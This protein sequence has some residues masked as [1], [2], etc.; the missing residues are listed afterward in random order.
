[1]KRIKGIVRTV[2]AIAGAISLNSPMMG[3]VAAGSG[4]GFASELN[5]HESVASKIGTLPTGVDKPVT[6]TGRVGKLER[7]GIGVDSKH[8]QKQG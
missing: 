6:M 4:Q 1:M 7:K 8:S 3:M 5:G 2:M